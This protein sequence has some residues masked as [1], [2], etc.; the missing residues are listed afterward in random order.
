[1]DTRS[2]VIGIERFASRRGIASVIWSDNG[3][4]FVATE[5]ELLRKIPNWN[6]QTLIE[7][8]VKKSINWKFNPPSAPHHGDVW[9]KLVRSFKHTVYAILGNR[10]VTDEILKTIFCLVEQSL[11][12]R[13]L[14]PARADATNM[15]ALTPN[16]CLL[17]SIG[18]SLPSHSICDFDY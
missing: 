17:G 11:T 18:S 6:Q 15:D 1:M 7:S 3:T 12:T 9:E 10:R 13:P 4:N 14:V 8:L 16:H 2:C 5:K